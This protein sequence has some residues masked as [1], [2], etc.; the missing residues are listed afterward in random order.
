MAQTSLRA[1]SKGIT[2][3]IIVAVAIFF[4][5]ILTYLGAAGQV[6][7]VEAQLNAKEKEVSESSKIARNLEESRLA[8]LDTRAQIRYLETSVSTQAYVPTLLEQLESLGKS[9]N[10]HVQGVRPQAPKA[11]PVTRRLNSGAQAAGG[12]VEGASQAKPNA[13][14]GAVQPKMEAK[15]YD[16]LQIDITLKGRYMNAIDFLYK[17]TSF[18]KIIA[19]NSVEM[20]SCATL[21]APG[22]PMLDVKVG[23]TAFI[24][25]DTDT[26][27]TLEVSADANARPVD[28]G[29]T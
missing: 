4:G 5:C 25:K 29:R 23:V 20:R 28:K 1:S 17:L 21:D 19:V 6:R 27:S 26:G 3:L 16:E 8:F 9:V 2:V 18:P 24:F 13:V 7:G 12:N 15:P 11:A 22:S 10:L 14:A